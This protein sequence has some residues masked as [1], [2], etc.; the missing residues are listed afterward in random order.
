MF[1]VE[2]KN[3][4]NKRN[5]NTVKQNKWNAANYDKEKKKNRQKKYSLLFK[6]LGLVK[7]FLRSQN[8]IYLK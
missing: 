2:C 1:N 8:C 7:S 6:I 5:M 4:G 3:C